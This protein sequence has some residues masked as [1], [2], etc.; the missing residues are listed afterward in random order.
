MGNSVIQAGLVPRP[1]PTG[2][3]LED[4]LVVTR[5]SGMCGM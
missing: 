5:I 3:D 4:R 1:H 2:K